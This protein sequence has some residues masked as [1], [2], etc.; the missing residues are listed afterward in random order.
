M[1]LLHCENY[2]NNIFESKQEWWKSENYGNL[3]AK[4]E[5]TVLAEIISTSFQNSFLYANMGRN[6]TAFH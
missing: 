1:Y 5:K 2:S 4:T 6:Q 3:K